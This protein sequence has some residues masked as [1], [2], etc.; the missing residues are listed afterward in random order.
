MRS[1]DGREDEAGRGEYLEAP[2]PLTCWASKS[3]THAWPEAAS[4]SLG[5]A[6][7]GGE[8]GGC[9]G[10]GRRGRGGEA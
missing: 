8:R 1:S 3:S 4:R 9:G 10:S 7:W 2:M 5:W 6:S